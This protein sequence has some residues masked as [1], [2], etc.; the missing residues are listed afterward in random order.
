MSSSSESERKGQNSSRAAPSSLLN[1]FTNK[2]ATS[3][4]RNLLLDVPRLNGSIGAARGKSMNPGENA[5]PIPEVEFEPRSSDSDMDSHQLNRPV[6]DDPLP[7]PKTRARHKLLR[8]FSKEDLKSKHMITTSTGGN[9]PAPKSTV[10]KFHLTDSKR[11][12]AN[13]G[14]L[15]MV[16]DDVAKALKA[17]NGQN[18]TIASRPVRR[19][20]GASIQDAAMFQSQVRSSETLSKYR[21]CWLTLSPRAMSKQQL[22]K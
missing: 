10:K 18:A 12:R 8:G 11:S 19:G 4:H 9:A 17:T 2:K 14:S 21:I 3:S 1:L 20:S 15:K 6:V 7:S 5:I 16:D 22:P 13:S